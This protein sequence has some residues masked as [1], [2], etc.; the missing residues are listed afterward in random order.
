[1]NLLKKNAAKAGDGSKGRYMRM[2]QKVSVY[3]LCSFSMARRGQDIC[4]SLFSA[5]MKMPLHTQ[6]HPNMCN[7]SCSK[8]YVKGALAQKCVE[9]FQKTFQ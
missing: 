5:I 1:M 2:L 8:F 9:Q 7:Q 4:G 3:F 6:L